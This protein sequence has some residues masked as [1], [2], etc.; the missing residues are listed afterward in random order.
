VIF[1]V[2]EMRA[3]QIAQ[4]MGIFYRG[5]IDRVTPGVNCNMAR[6]FQWGR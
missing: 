3:D 2:G 5:L 6:T 1:G 4:D